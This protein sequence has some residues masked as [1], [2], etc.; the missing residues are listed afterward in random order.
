VLFW[1]VLV[2]W[3]LDWVGGDLACITVGVF[4]LAAVPLR[5]GGVFLGGYEGMRRGVGWA[6]MNGMLGGGWC[7]A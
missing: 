2:L 4:F 1:G 3:E 6:I 7:I 5:A